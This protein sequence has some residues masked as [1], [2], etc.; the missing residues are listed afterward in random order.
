MVGIVVV[1]KNPK[2]LDLFFSF[3]IIECVCFAYK[4][5]WRDFYEEYCYSEFDIDIL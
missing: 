3:H 4:I 2:L 1:V 5:E